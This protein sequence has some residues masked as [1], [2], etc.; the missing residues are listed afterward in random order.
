M[1]RRAGSLSVAA[2]ASLWGTT[3][4]VAYLISD[5]VGPLLVGAITMGLGGVILLVVAGRSGIVLW[6]DRTLRVPMVA[7]SVAVAIYPLAFYTAMSVAGVAVGNIIALATGPLVGAALE[8]LFDSRSPGSR[9]WWALAVGVTGVAVVT[10]SG[11]GAGPASSTRFV[12][13][14]V[15]AVIAGIAYGG[16]SYCLARVM[17]AGVSSVAATGAIFGAGSIPLLVVVGLS[18]SSLADLGSSGWG[19]AYLV[20]GPMVLSYLLYGRGLSVLAPSTVLVIALVEPAVATIL[21]VTVVGERMGPWASLGL[22]AIA[23]A[24]VL[25]SWAKSAR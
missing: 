19:L 1:T 9:W 24:V 20:A 2:A 11:D 23:F 22:A 7:G 5:R 16:Y 21:A 6:R 17:R 18:A 3:G 12:W 15:L 25:V 10:V 14:I 4:T 13:G 8:W